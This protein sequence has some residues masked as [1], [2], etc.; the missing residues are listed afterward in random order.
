M[1]PWARQPWR[2]GWRYTISRSH[3]TWMTRRIWWINHRIVSCHTNQKHIQD[4]KLKSFYFTLQITNCLT[5]FKQVSDKL[6]QQMSCTL[7]EKSG[8]PWIIIVLVQ[9]ST[10]IIDSWMQEATVGTPGAIATS[11]KSTHRS[12]K[13]MLWT[14]FSDFSFLTIIILE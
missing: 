10:F 7:L 2:R 1:N 11:I 9:N 13:R 14:R 5:T 12:H 8:K 4:M 6:P 3:H